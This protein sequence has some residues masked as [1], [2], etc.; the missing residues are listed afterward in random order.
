MLLPRRLLALL[1]ASLFLLAGCGGGADGGTTTPDTPAPPNPTIA[2]TARSTSATHAAVSWSGG[3]AGTPLRLE[4]RTGE[5]GDYVLIATVDGDAGLWLDGGL[6]ADTAYAYRLSRADGSVAAAAATR[7]GTEAALT[8]AAPEA[9]GAALALPFTSATS[10]LSAADGSLQL[11]LPTGSFSQAGTATLQPTTNPLPDGVG[12]GLTLSLPERPAR[13][14]TL[15]LR[16]GADEDVDEVSQDRIALRQADGSWWLLP[17]AAHDESR[18]LLQV[19]LPP[20]LWMAEPTAAALQA[21][22]SAATAGAHLYFVRV[23]AH[24]LLPAAATVRVLGQQRFVPVSIYQMQENVSDCESLSADELC[25]PTPVRHDV[26]V[27]I[28]NTKPGFTREWTLQGSTTPDA[29]F[30]TLAAEPSAG[31][32][33]T[34][35]AQVPATNPLKLRFRSVN[36]ANG[37]RLVLSA[38]IR[39]TEDAWVGKL[40]A[41]VGPEGQGSMIEVDSRWTLDA[42]RS[43]ATRRVY[44]PSGTTT[45]DYVVANSPCEYVVSPREVTLAQARSSGQLVV[46]ESTTPSRYTLEL[47]TIWDATLSHICPR[48]TASGSYAGGHTWSAEGSVANG[49]I[50]GSDNTL[51]DR[52]WSLGRPQ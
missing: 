41:H 14:L 33:Y 17:L 16:Y 28:L 47:G 31:V 20:S 3:S 29:S 12:P 49:R 9:V 27:Q 6:S 44:L 23:R 43:T 30:G 26:V 48:G 5:G 7:T 24:K 11:D 2:L 36:S 4:R 15:S 13:T 46:D 37:R 32:V 50:T 35:P 38:S 34:A 45:Q 51:G 18:R 10:R 39:V 19:K 52:K 22:S 21:R 25:V 8:T 40:N 42:A 1:G